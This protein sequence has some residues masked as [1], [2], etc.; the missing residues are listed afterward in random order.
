MMQFRLLCLQKKE[1]FDKKDQSY[2]VRRQLQEIK[3][4]PDETIEEFAERTEN[5]A[6]EGYEGMPDYFINSHHGFITL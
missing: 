3:Q 6:A 4:N 2:I 5:M 1:R